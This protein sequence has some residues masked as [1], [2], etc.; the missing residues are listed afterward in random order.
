MF[1]LAVV[2]M[3]M[4][5]DIMENSKPHSKESSRF[6]V[7]KCAPNIDIELP[8]MPAH[9]VDKVASRVDTAAKAFPTFHNNVDFDELSIDASFVMLTTKKIWLIQIFSIGEPQKLLL[10]TKVQIYKT[11]FLGTC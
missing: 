4:V 10:H 1:T 7:G 6:S 5:V 2:V 8:T 11:N 9:F 3:M